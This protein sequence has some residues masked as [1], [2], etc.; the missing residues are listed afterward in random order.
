M[1]GFVTFADGGQ[2]ESPD[3]HCGQHDALHLLPTSS[4]YPD[5]NTNSNTSEAKFSHTWFA[6]S[7]HFRGDLSIGGGVSV[8]SN[9]ELN[10]EQCSITRMAVISVHAYIHLIVYAAV[11][12]NGN[13]DGCVVGQR[14]D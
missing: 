2:K 9:E 8:V 4:I 1:Q 5:S 6:F 13:Q 12:S 14:V 11:L 3:L 7:R 10:D